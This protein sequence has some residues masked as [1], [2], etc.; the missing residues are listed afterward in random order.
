MRIAVNHDSFTVGRRSGLHLPIPSARVSGRHAE[1]LLVGGHLFIRDLG[2]T[3]GTFVNHERLERT[4][5]LEVGDHVEFA[6][7]EFMVEYSS[8]GPPEDHLLATLKKTHQCVG[9]L[10]SDWVFSQF[11]Q[12]MEMRAIVPHYQPLVRMDDLR[13]CG[14]E[15]L[16]RSEINGLTNPKTMFET[17]HLLGRSVELSFVCRERAIE[18]AEGFGSGYQIFVNTHPD[19]APDRDVMPHI[20]ALRERHPHIPLVLEVHEASIHDI[21]TMR[22][23]TAELKELGVLLAY[24]DFGAGQSRLL[25]LVQAP[26][27]VLKF[28][29]NLIRGIDQA[30]VSQ[31]RMLRMLVEM[32]RDF[33]TAT[34]AEGIETAAEADVCRELGFD[35]AQG[36]LYGRPMRF[37]Q[38]QT[39][40]RDQVC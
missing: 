23:V 2:S 12:L 39:E 5:R 15:A 29:M 22:S 25:E 6:D 37:E 27:D 31:R 9:S 19:E 3:N 17:S 28:D 35:F 8:D 36:Y 24:D 40:S 21:R 14:F 33:S 16:A 13:V 34:L 7:M 4:R 11:A 26:P 38:I 30:P 20:R 10:E 32:T 1:L 18:I